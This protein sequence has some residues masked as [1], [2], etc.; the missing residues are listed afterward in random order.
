LRAEAGK[1]SSD[2]RS[3]Q[4]AGPAG[5]SCDRLEAVGGQQAGLDRGRVEFPGSA[6]EAFEIFRRQRASVSVLVA[7]RQL[8]EDVVFDAGHSTGLR[9]CKAGRRH[10][11][12]VKPHAQG[13]PPSVQ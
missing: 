6:R 7:N 10:A 2:H 4:R 3:R 5:D 1:L 11:K 8:V 13:A 9:S 12:R